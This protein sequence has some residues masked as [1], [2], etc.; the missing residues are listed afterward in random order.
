MSLFETDTF[1]ADAP[2]KPASK[3]Q[4]SAVQLPPLEQRQLNFLDWQKQAEP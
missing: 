4:Q 2:Q 3:K 1:S